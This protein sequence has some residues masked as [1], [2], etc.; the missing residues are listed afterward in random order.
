MS[1]LEGAVA[2]DA[3][4]NEEELKAFWW[5][6]LDRPA[7]G[8]LYGATVANSQL[9][10][11]YLPPGFSTFVRVYNDSWKDVLRF[12]QKSFT[13]CEICQQLKASLAEKELSLEKKLGCL[14]AYRNHLKD[15]YDDRSRLWELE[16]MSADP[17]SNV[18]L[19]SV[20]GMDQAKF[21]VPRDPQLRCSSALS[22]AIRPRMMVHA[23]HAHG[24]TLHI[25]VA[26]ETVKH[27]S[28][29]VLDLVAETLEKVHDI[30][31]DRK[32]RMPD[33][34]ILAVGDNCVREN[35]NSFV[36]SFQSLLVQRFKARVAGLAFLR[37]SHTHNGLDQLFGILARRLASTDRILND[38][39]V[40][41]VLRP[42]VR[43]WLGTNV[44]VC[45][46]KTPAVRAWADHVGKTGVKLEGG[47]LCDKT[48]NHFFLFMLYRDLPVPLQE[49]VKRRRGFSAPA[50]L[51]VVVLVKEY[52]CSDDLGQEPQ[53][54]LPVSRCLHGGLIPSGKHPLRDKESA[55][56]SWTKTGLLVIQAYGAAGLNSF[57]L[58]SYEEYRRAYDY[59]QRLVNDDMWRQAPLRS[60]PW[61]DSIG[62]RPGVNDAEACLHQSVLDALAPKVPLRVVF[63][64]RANAE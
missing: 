36:L 55:K 44:S 8:P 33:Q 64:R 58:A 3:D 21:A 17:S 10:R 28:S 29:F 14:L 15:Q 22:S 59:L 45:V 11:R 49:R 2:S 9:V 60:L 1:E 27:D 25:R 50:A 18:L 42:G 6:W 38:E 31:V 54:V 5:A 51:D 53:V 47:L 41:E 4:D 13:T 23:C 56:V 19:L 20:D 61:L 43:S 37:K 35:K 52:I 57:S 39:D 63:Q 62:Q 24:Y 48:S 30:C 40:I 16:A 34:I 7:S 26:D 46:E 12:R 32:Q